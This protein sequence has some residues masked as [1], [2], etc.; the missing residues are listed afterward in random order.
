MRKNFSVFIKN[1]INQFNRSISTI[2]GCKSTSFRALIFS[3]QAIGISHLKGVLESDDI[4][5][6]IKSLKDL[7]VRIIKIKSG[8]YKIYGNGEN[9]YVQPKNKYLYFGN[10]G[11][12]GILMGFLATNS[13]IKVK[14][15][16]DRSLQSRSME[17]FIIPLSKIGC[18]FY[19]EG[20]KNFPITIEGTDYGLA[21]HHVVNG[22]AQEKACILNAALSL[23]GTTTIEDRKPCGRNHS[24]IMLRAIGARIF[25]K[26]RKKYNLISLSGHQNLQ[27]FSLDIPGDPSSAAF[28]CILCLMTKNS[29]IK[30][31][32]I[33]L[34]NFRIGYIRCLKSIGA[35][36]NLTNVKMKF[37]EPVGD[38][39]VKF[40]K[41]RPINFPK[42]E[43]ISTIDELPALMTLAATIDGVSTFNLGSK[44]IKILEGKESSRVKRM[45]ENLKAFGIKT[46]ITRDKIKVY[47][48]T[49]EIYSKRKKININA[50]LDHRIQMS[51]ILLG[52]VS[53]SIVTV[54][55]CETIKTSFP[56]FFELLK[57]CGIKYEIKKN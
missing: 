49:L 26:K 2:P 42:K 24:E 27:S 4:K 31:K 7:G 43:V 55:G 20:K 29:K 36:I 53:K 16:G 12:L 15:L 54:K 39:A 32:K 11:T 52:A 51:A 44:N 57:K 3:S 30:L 10:A 33:N 19:P 1:K 13:S 47:G 45:S 40:S 5:C 35:N 34:N 22:S 21:Q 56:N 17:K 41:L 18:T 9:S 28:L 48:S 46:K 8:E 38:I 23:S 6:C 14:I 25:I 50:V 37:G